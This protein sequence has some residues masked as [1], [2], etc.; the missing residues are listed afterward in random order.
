ML[1]PHDEALAFLLAQGVAFVAVDA[2]GAEI[3]GRDP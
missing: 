3:R 2:Q 1:M